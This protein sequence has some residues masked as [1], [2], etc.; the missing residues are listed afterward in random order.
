MK[1]DFQKFHGEISALIAKTR[2]EGYAIVGCLM[3][4]EADAF[5]MIPF[6]HGVK[7]DK[8]NETESMAELFMDIAMKMTLS[9]PVTPYTEQAITPTKTKQD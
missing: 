1:G 4:R 7:L 6:G 2:S 5:A 9:E 8:G 3:K